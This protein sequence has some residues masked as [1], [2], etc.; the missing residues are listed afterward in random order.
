MPRIMLPLMTVIALLVGLTAGASAHEGDDTST[1][2][3]PMS[4]RAAMYN[5]YTYSR[6]QSPR[7]VCVESRLGSGWTSQKAA[8]AEWNRVPEMRVIH[9][10]GKGGCRG[11]AKRIILT[12]TSKP[13]SPHRAWVDWDASA[14]KKWGKDNTG[15]LVWLNRSPV[16]I[17][18]N[19]GYSR[20]RTWQQNKMTITHELGHAI[21]NPI[22]SEWNGHTTR[23]DS[24]MSSSFTCIHKQSGLTTYDRATIAR[25]YRDWR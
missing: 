22:G 24:V 15:K 6:W 3:R 10:A 13:T 9:R 5:E 17:R 16:Y 7:T 14:A 18:I 23:C 8:V 19:V 4:A 11:W 25:I 12:R 20:P 1:E 2:D 21:M